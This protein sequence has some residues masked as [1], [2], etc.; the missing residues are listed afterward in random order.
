MRLSALYKG[1]KKANGVATSAGEVL[2]ET[3]AQAAAI[4]GVKESFPEVARELMGALRPF[5]E[6]AEERAD[7][8]RQV[9][10]WE[11]FER[12]VSRAG[13]MWGSGRM[14]TRVT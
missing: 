8:V 3:R 14:G 1:G 5:P 11:R 6:L 10:T 13:R 4:N 9:C 2:G 7:W 12:A